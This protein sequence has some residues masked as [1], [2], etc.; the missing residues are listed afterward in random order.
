MGKPEF[1][2]LCGLPGSGKSTLAKKHEAEGWL[3]INYDDLRWDTHLP[4]DHGREREMKV[5]ALSLARKALEEGQ[6]VI[7]D[8]TNLNEK[9]RKPWIDLAKEFGLEAEILEM[10]TSVEDCVLNDSKRE[11]F[12]RV[13]RAVIE[14]MALFNGFIDWNDRD[15]YPRPFVICDIDGTIAD[16]SHRRSYVVQKPKDWLSFFKNVHLDKAIWPIMRLVDLLEKDYHILICSGRPIDRCGLATEKW[17]RDNMVPCKHL[18]MRNGGDFRQDNLVKE[19]ILQLLPK[20]RIRYVIDDRNQ[21][22]KMWRKH[23]LTTLQVADGDF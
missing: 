5:K 17:L 21:V 22:V 9:A 11:G 18:F 16:L 1:V 7:I 3:R 14:R 20:E 4:F 15:I 8:N 12:A 10:S 6:S 13:G 19:E 23:G 2:I